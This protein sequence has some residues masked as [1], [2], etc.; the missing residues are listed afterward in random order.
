M[1]LPRSF[2]SRGKYVRLIGNRFWQNL[3]EKAAVLLMQ[4]WRQLIQGGFIPLENNERVVLERLTE[5]PTLILVAYYVAEIQQPSSAG[6]GIYA[7]LPF[8][9]LID[10]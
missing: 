10:V 4:S 3:G 8:S 1:Q 2:A 5:Q 7:Q 9:Y 6:R